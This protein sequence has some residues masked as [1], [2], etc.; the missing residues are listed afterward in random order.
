MT[1]H[2]LDLAVP[3]SHPALPGHFAG[4][5]IVPAAWI[6]TLV[7]AACREAFPGFVPMAIPHARFRA[8]LGPDAPLRVE[9]VRR[10]DGGVEFRCTSAG[11]RIAD[12]VVEP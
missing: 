3:A 6:L 2:V 1:T 8:P 11:A 12:G 5:P 9:L 4:R 10:D 7:D